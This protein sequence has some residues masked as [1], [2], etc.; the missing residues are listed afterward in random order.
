MITTAI[1]HTN[2][3][4]RH[5]GIDASDVAKVIGHALTARRPRTRYLVGRDGIV[6][7]M[8]A[9]LLPD[10]MTDRLLLSQIKSDRDKAA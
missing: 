9:K 4:N 6:T 2:N 3:I 10:R 5:T 8:V 7:A 1:E